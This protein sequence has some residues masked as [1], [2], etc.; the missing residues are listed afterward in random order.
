MT[1]PDRP[2]SGRTMPYPPLL[3]VVGG[4]VA[5]GVVTH[6]PLLWT[7]VAAGVA[8]LYAGYRAFRSRQ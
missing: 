1:R 2:A 7:L 5:L 8:A 4:L 3:V 6:K